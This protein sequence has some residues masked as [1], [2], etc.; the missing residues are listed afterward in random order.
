MKE[1]L[2]KNKNAQTAFGL[3]MTLLLLISI[4]IWF[5]LIAASLWNLLLFPLIFSLVQFCLTPLLRGLGIFHYYSHFLMANTSDS[6]AV[7]LHTG[8]TFDFILHFSLRDFGSRSKLNIITEV[9]N[10]L[11]RIIHDIENGSIHRNKKIIAAPYFLSKRTIQK[12]GFKVKE[13]SLLDRVF[14]IGSFFDILLMYIFT[15]RKF[16]LPEVWKVKSV[17]LSAWQLLAKKGDLIN[18]KKRLKG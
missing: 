5:K 4:A 9:V 10:G 8:T 3:G 6:S 14:I 12:F 2:L 11:L 17:E 1:Q 18:L 7:E 13:P 16:T 15:H